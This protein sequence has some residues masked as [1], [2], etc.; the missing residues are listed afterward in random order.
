MAPS[1]VPNNWSDCCASA[2][3]NWGTKC[4]YSGCEPHSGLLMSLCGWWLLGNKRTPSGIPRWSP[5]WSHFLKVLTAG[6][7]WWYLWFCAFCA[8]AGYA[9]FL[10][11]NLFSQCRHLP[12]KN[13]N[14]IP[15][16]SYTIAINSI[17]CSVLFW[18]KSILIWGLWL[19]RCLCNSK[20]ENICSKIMKIKW[21]FGWKKAH[22]CKM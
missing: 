16:A 17:I 3:L 14:A 11:W 4:C 10:T 13:T 9:T 20:L 1:G 15:S 19:L 7:D 18:D 5:F 8:D 21:L 22:S 12:E 6:T 2:K